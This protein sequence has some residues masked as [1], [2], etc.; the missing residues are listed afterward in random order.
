M[1]NNRLWFLKGMAVYRIHTD[2]QEIFEP[3]HP[4]PTF[5]LRDACWSILRGD[6]GGAR[7][8]LRAFSRAA[9]DWIGEIAARVV[10]AEKSDPGRPFSYWST[11]GIY[12]PGI[13]IESHELEAAAAE[14]RRGWIAAKEKYWKLNFA[15]QQIQKHYYRRFGTT[16][17]YF[18]GRSTHPAV[19]VYHEIRRKISKI[20]KIL[21][22][23][24]FEGCR[25]GP[26]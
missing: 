5:L 26:A 18:R 8:M 15:F 9:Q 25:R 16:F 14:A 13:K 24:R 4:D 2:N 22:T 19:Y 11:G 12:K 10:W 23:R 6:E 21:G 7:G 1:D 17:C 20:S 3:V